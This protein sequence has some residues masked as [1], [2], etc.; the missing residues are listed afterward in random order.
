VEWPA[1]DGATV[2]G[3]L[4][5]PSHPLADPPPL[6]VWIHGGPTGQWVVG[7]QPRFAYFLD[8]GWAILLPDHRGSTGYGRAYAQALAGRWGELDVSDTAAGMRAAAERGWGDPQRMVPMGGSAGGFTVL[9][10]LARHPELCAAGVDLFGV[11]DLFDLDETTHRFEAHYLHR[12]VGP[13]PETAERYRERSPV[14]VV[15]SIRAPLLVLQGEDDNVVPPAQSRAMVERLRSLGRTVELHEYPGEGHGWVKPETVVDE[16][17]RIESFLRRY[18]LL[19][20][21]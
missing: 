15:E 6:L 11:T 16:L 12:I 10:L 17:G 13:L 21:Q 20:H 4:Y 2:H 3:R 5:R 1:D 18:V 8:R 14:T 19:R 7:F 9:N